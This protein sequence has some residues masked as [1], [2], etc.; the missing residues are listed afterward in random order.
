VCAPLVQDNVV[1]EAGGAGIACEAGSQAV[2]RGN[3]IVRCK[4]GILLQVSSICELHVLCV[5]AVA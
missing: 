5:P 2:L 4:T 3:R 1:E